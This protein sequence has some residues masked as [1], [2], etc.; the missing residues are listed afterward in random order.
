MEKLFTELTSVYGFVGICLYD[1]E[2]GRMA[3]AMPETYPEEDLAEIADMLIAAYQSGD[4]DFGPLHDVTVY[5]GTKL[6]LLRKITNHAFVYVLAEPDT[7]LFLLRI[8]LSLVSDDLLH[9]SEVSL[10]S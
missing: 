10:Q 8:A 5:E 1:A 7:N 2:T 3:K 6:F 4:S 9:Q